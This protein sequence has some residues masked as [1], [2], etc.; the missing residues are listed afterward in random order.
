MK[1]NVNQKFNI[2]ITQK[3]IAEIID[4][5]YDASRILK[6]KQIPYRIEK[7]GTFGVKIMR[8]IQSEVRQYVSDNDLPK[9]KET[10][11][12]LIK[13]RM[14]TFRLES[15]DVY[16]NQQLIKTNQQVIC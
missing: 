1:N 4:S 6:R 15:K 11:Q 8:M 14:K 13:E 10:Y 3:Q 5:Q 9:T 7:I 16:I 12:E 2:N